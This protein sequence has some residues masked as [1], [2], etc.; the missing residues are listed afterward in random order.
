MAW[1]IM[2]FLTLGPLMT[3]CLIAL[4][5]P[6][7]ATYTPKPLTEDSDLQLS[8]RALAIS[9]N[10][11]PLPERGSHRFDP[12]RPLDM[13]DVALLAV[14]HN[15]DLRA[16]R[17]KIGVAEAQAFA[18]GILPNP[19]VAFSYG[20]LTGGPGSADS[21]LA[22]LS[23]DV[24]PLLTFSTR[25]AAADAAKS[26]VQLDLAWQEW[27]IVSRARLLF[28]DAV[29]LAKQRRLIE[30]NLRL[31]R[32]RQEQTARAMRMGNEVLQ[33]VTVDLVAFSAAESEL[34]AIEELMLK[35]KHDLNA[36][37]GVT[38]DALLPLTT[39]IRAPVLDGAK[40]EPLLMDLA[41]R[42]PDLLALQAAYAAEEERV[43]QTII[44][45]FPRLSVGPSYSRDTTA[46]RSLPTG[47]TI[48]LPIFDRNQ[49]N[50]AI[51]HATREQLWEE[52]RARLATAYGEA[53]RLI[54]E[55]QLLEAHYR[56]SLESVRKL[57]ETVIT[58]EPAF[59]A[60]N[61]DERTFL[62]LRT[63]L[64]AKEITTAKLEQAIWE[65]RIGLQTLIGSHLPDRRLDTGRTL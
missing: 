30:E 50:I 57:R 9:A 29:S 61:L 26:S 53:K 24:F 20:L 16:A 60:G 63:S 3:S 6:S 38:P 47:I 18:A 34:H 51:E 12:R 40:I 42:R 48:S 64:L 49:G 2:K 33:T 39:S 19:Q 1:P 45:Q 36:L 54:S 22:S 28:V 14:A 25:K 43:W 4:A 55:L 8:G 11:F 65:Q 27:Q 52:Y 10:E 15:P 5:L 37:L 23:Q 41:A 62:D 31:F 21:I 44:E 32:R 17:A 56:S 46:I 59:S 58:A 13:D 35:N 7:C